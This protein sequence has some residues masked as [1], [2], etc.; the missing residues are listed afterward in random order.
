[1]M[2][3]SRKWWVLTVLTNKQENELA[4]YIKKMDAVLYGISITE[5]QLIV[6]DYAEK[7]QD[8]FKKE[9]KHA[10]QD[11]VAGFLKP[12]N[13][14]SPKSEGVALDILFGLLNTHNFEPGRICNCDESGLTCAT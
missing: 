4:D 12:Q 11:F 2:L 6:Y 14:S 3:L 1:M 7:K 5:L 9:K 13:I 8:R 10:V